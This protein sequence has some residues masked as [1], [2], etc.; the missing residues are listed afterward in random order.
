MALEYLKEK[1]V[2]ECVQV[3]PGNDSDKE[4]KIEL[5]LSKQDTGYFDVNHWNGSESED[6]C[7]GK[8]VSRLQWDCIFDSD[9]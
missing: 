5:T 4:V 6:D 3:R 7:F 9:G 8:S 2:I 1:R